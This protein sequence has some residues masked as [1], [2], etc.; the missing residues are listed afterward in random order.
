[1]TYLGK[2]ALLDLYKQVSRIE[3]DK[4]KG[5]FIEA[6]CALS[7]SAIVIAALN[8]KIVILIFMMF[9]ILFHPLLKKTVMMYKN[10]IMISSAE[11]RKE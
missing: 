4:I 10:D 7:G 1:M 6:G 3:K 2:D 5:L 9:L 11:V 8:Q